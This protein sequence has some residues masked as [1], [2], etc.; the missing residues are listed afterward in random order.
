MG[1]YMLYPE[2][3]LIRKCLDMISEQKEFSLVYDNG[4]SEALS[5]A[6]FTAYLITRD[7]NLKATIIGNNKNAKAFS[8]SY[9]EKMKDINKRYRRSIMNIMDSFSKK[10]ETTVINVVN[11]I[12][13]KLKYKIDSDIVYVSWFLGVYFGSIENQMHMS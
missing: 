9:K 5:T 11:Y 1:K 12:L 6:Y 3:T 13:E 8:E 7:V 4:S 2:E 10:N